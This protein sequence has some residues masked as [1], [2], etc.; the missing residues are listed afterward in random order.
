MSWLHIAPQLARLSNSAQ[1]PIAFHLRPT[2][3]FSL[4]W[5]SVFRYLAIASCPVSLSLIWLALSSSLAYTQAFA[6]MLSFNLC[7]LQPKGQASPA[8]PL[9]L[10]PA[11]GTPI[12][13]NLSH[14]PV[15]WS[16]LDMDQF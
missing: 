15:K 3:V 9:N 6:W 12:C 14:L 4:R 5:S 10:P 8:L 7:A 11:P 1:A 13:C 16:G 2:L